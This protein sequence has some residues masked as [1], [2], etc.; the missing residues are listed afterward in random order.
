[1]GSD[2][3]SSWS[4]LI[5]LLTINNASKSCTWNSKQ[6]SP[7]SYWEV[8]S[9]STFC[10]P[11]PVCPKTSLN[12][13]LLTLCDPRFVTEHGSKTVSPA[14]ASIVAGL[15]SNTGNGVFSISSYIG[16]W[17]YISDITEKRNIHFVNNNKKKM[18]FTMSGH[19]MCSLPM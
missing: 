13:L 5:F 6:R 17:Q 7:W 16:I 12:I 1:M 11:R 14:E 4:L 9:G 10:L 3:I 2:C 18:I 15:V 8:W 19:E